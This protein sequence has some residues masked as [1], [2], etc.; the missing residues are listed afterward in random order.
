MGFSCTSG[1]LQGS[2][3]AFAGLQNSVLP[4]VD[5]LVAHLDFGFLFCFLA[6]PPRSR[7]PARW[8]QRGISRAPQTSLGGERSGAEQ[9]R[10]EQGSP[11]NKRTHKLSSPLHPTPLENVYFALGPVLIFTKQSGE[12]RGIGLPVMSFIRAWTII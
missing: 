12:T 4:W 11:G 9:S 5:L 10:A 6:L 2:C 3:I 7:P 1:G 8:G